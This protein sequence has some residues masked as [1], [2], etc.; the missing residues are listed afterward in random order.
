MRKK[1][2]KKE[3]GIFVYCCTLEYVFF[4]PLFLPF[5]VPALFVPP[6]PPFPVSA[7]LL[8]TLPPFPAV[9]SPNAAATR[10]RTINVLCRPCRI[11]MRIQKRDCQRL[12]FV[13][14][15]SLG[16]DS[17]PKDALDIHAVLSGADI[18]RC[19]HILR[20]CTR[21]FMVMFF[22]QVL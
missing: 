4:S 5:P 9:S 2:K 16:L 8:P 15:R 21:T 6:L 3:K 17:R 7:P 10:R 18:S 20:K 1:K 11:P 22:S 14:W 19:A 13:L 12:S